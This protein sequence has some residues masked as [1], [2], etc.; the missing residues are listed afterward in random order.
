MFVFY[1]HGNFG[2]CFFPDSQESSLNILPS[3]YAARPGLRIWRATIEGKVT[4]TMIFKDLIAKGEPEISTLNLA[5]QS[6]ENGPHLDPKQFG[7][8]KV[9]S[10]S[11]LISWQGSCVWV[12]DPKMGLTVGCHSNFGCVVDVATWGTEMF[13]LTKGDSSFVR[14][15]SLETSPQSPVI[16]GRE[17]DLTP[18]DGIPRSG[19]V[20][21][22]E[23]TDKLDRIFGEVKNTTVG[24]I[25]VVKRN[26]VKT[27]GHI[28]N[29]DDSE[30]D[31]SSSSD[32]ISS[33][34]S[35]REKDQNVSFDNSP[36]V[37][38]QIRVSTNIDIKTNGEEISSSPQ[39]NSPCLII[40]SPVHESIDDASTEKHD[41]VIAK[42][43]LEQNDDEVSG[44]TTTNKIDVVIKHDLKETPIPF[45]H[46]SG[47][48]FSSDIVFEGTSRQKSRRKRKAKKGIL[49]LSF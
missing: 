19:S 24:I 41:E 26:V 4:T 37:E 22:F 28:K 46:I 38:D 32:N 43:S 20:N 9:L 21:Q 8:L 33:D 1:R 35:P 12:V 25:S 15:I 14:K 29:M 44:E 49:S 7:P 11:F 30:E 23:E 39:V 31:R 42:T 16:E 36:P 40:P 47:K 5:S 2:A 6:G 3:V 48:A 34:S 17:L 45:H 10:D 18:I 13:V 27:I